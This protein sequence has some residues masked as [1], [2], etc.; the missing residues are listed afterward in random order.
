M[1]LGWIWWG[2][3][4]RVDQ[5]KKVMFFLFRSLKMLEAVRSSSFIPLLCLAVDLVWYLLVEYPPSFLLFLNLV[6]LDFLPVVSFSMSLNLCLISSLPNSILSS[7]SFLS[8]NWLDVM[9]YSSSKFMKFCFIFWS[10]P[11]VKPSS[12]SLLYSLESMVMEDGL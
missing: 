12:S 10:S 11:V 4:D 9:F 8:S 5:F 6:P 3:T 1:L 7:S 2:Y